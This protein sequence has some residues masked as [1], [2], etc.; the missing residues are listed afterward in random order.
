MVIINQL[1]LQ[2]LRSFKR[3]F[4]K[5]GKEKNGFVPQPKLCVMR[6]KKENPQVWDIVIHLIEVCLRYNSARV[7]LSTSETTFNVHSKQ[8]ITVETFLVHTYIAQR[9]V[10]AVSYC[11]PTNAH[12][13]WDDS[14]VTAVSIRHSVSSIVSGRSHLA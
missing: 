6:L 11:L 5:F 9:Q 1:Y 10:K 14:E 4:A 13:T 2:Y 12:W 3:T 8:I 7:S